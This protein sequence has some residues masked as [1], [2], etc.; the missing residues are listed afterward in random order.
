MADE[1]DIVAVAVDIVAAA[2][3]INPVDFYFRI[4][5][6]RFVGVIHGLH[7]TLLLWHCVVHNTQGGHCN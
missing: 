5:V 2:V 7:H 4:A 1:V 6:D 3:V